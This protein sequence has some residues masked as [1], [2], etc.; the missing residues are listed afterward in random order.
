M[1]KGL[2]IGEVAKRSGVSRGAIRL[3]EKQGIIARAR[4]TES[5][6]RVYSS[7]VI[8][9]LAFVG[10]ARGLGLT[11][12]EIAAVAAQRR[13]GSSPCIHVRALLEQKAAD[14]AVMLRS[15]RAI[16]RSWPKHE[17]HRAAVCPHIEA[18]GGAVIWKDTRSVLAARSAQKS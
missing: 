4:R 9:V 6:Y 5:G 1:A 18:R 7:D 12:S 10:E 8:G 14:L 13:N 11:L 3:Y 17:G 2:L 15:I 16:L